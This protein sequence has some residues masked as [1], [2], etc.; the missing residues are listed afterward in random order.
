MGGWGEPLRFAQRIDWR[1]AKND[2]NAASVA[3]GL[4]GGDGIWPQIRDR[5]YW[6]DISYNQDLLTA[7]LRTLAHNAVSDESMNEFQGN[8]P[9]GG[10]VSTPVDSIGASITDT[11]RMSTMQ[12]SH[13]DATHYLP[14]YPHNGDTPDGS[15]PREGGFAG[16]RKEDGVDWLWEDVFDQEFSCQDDTGILEIGYRPQ[17]SDMISVDETA[18]V[19]PETD[20]V[21]RDYTLTNE[22]STSFTGRFVYYTQANVTDEKQNPMIWHSHRN[23][24][25]ADDR[26]TWV[27][28]ESN[29]TLH[30]GMDQPVAESGVAETRLEELFEDAADTVT[31]RYLNGFLDADVSLAP[32]E[33]TSLTV[34]ITDTGE[35]DNL[36]TPAATRQDRTMQW[37]EGW[38]DD[39]DSADMDDTDTQ[40]YRR[41]VKTLGLLVDPD[42]GMIPA[43]PDLVPMYYPSWIRD[44]AFSAVALARAGKPEPAKRFLAD[45]CP[46]VQE[47][48]GSFK[49]CYHRDGTFAG[50]IEIE[51]DQQ[52]IYAWAVQ[53]VYQ[54]TG[55]EAFLEDSWPAVEQALD[56]TIDAMVDNDLL[57]AT[58]D[59][60]EMPSDVRQS[61][62]ANTFAYRAL[63]DGADMAEALGQD[64]STYQDAAETVGDAVADRFFEDEYATHLTATGPAVTYNTPYAAIAWPT[65][66]M[67][68]YGHGDQLLDDLY[69]NFASNTDEYWVPGAAMLAASL[70]NQDETVK[71]ENVMDN[72]QTAQTPSNNIAEEVN[73][74]EQRFAS[75]LGWAQAAYILAVDEKYSA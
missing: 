24:V 23:T 71:A 66:W 44:G 17:R 70:Y 33:Q 58:P 34:G 37:W 13:S 18:Y 43:A 3:L 48:D 6:T 32:G 47:E 26:L 69:H 74:S 9:Q 68:A 67:D 60:A 15:K 12:A 27:D 38:M 42:S 21:F 30:I 35:L 8:S 72:V 49:M 11:G 22:T 31:G 4:R 50:Y 28:E 16:I 1:N 14:Y 5:Q 46:A 75:P 10:Y 45:Y 7:Q 65:G 56:Y 36:E 25:T 73:G 54:E 2:W 51:N 61:T 64:G 59:Y 41:A 40:Q 52:P 62:W 29:N 53:T 19:L 39:I 63:L 20:T 55:D 57:A